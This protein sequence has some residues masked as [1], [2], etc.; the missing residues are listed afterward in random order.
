MG[1]FERTQLYYE[2]KRL[3]ESHPRLRSAIKQSI[4]RQ[5]MVLG[6][7]NVVVLRDKLHKVTP[8]IVSPK[9]TFEAAREYAGKKVCV[10]NFASATNP[11][12]GAERG[13]SAQ[14]EALCRCSTL[15]PCLL[16]SEAEN[17]FYGPH[18][19]A[20][21]PL[22]NDDCIYTPDVIVMRDDVTDKLLPE[23]Q[24]FPVDV[25]SC[26]A[27][28]LRNGMSCTM[29][30]LRELF[31]SR[32]ERIMALAAAHGADVLI[33]GAFG[34]GVFRCPPV[35]VAEVMREVTQKYQGC[36]E[37]IEF[38]VYCQQSNDS[39]YRAFCDVFLA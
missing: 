1:R 34:C 18:R 17:C 36:F 5:E 4:A 10:L 33:L 7:D 29:D 11:G 32:I 28:N 16:T 25:I 20:H 21:D 19:A 14:E 15:H 6:D 38:A 30:Q 35:L 37:A 27:P 31:K 39:N 22:Y 26:A 2:T 23:D 12:G 3:Y 9:K 24:W 13:S 8:I